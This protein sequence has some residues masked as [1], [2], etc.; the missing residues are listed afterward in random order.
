MKGTRDARHLPYGGKSQTL[1]SVRVFRTKNPNLSADEASS[2]SHAKELKPSILSYC[3]GGQ[4]LCTKEITCDVPSAII[5]QALLRWY[6]F[7]SKINHE[8]RPDCYPMGANN[9]KF[10]AKVSVPLI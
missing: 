6:L 1:F 2:G 9:L 4:G 7:S 10:P 3:L 8:P 5:Y